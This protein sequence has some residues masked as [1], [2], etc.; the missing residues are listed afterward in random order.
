MKRFKPI[1]WLFLFGSIWGINEVFLGEILYRNDVQNSSVILTVMALFLLAISRGMINKPGSSALI[2]TFAVLFRLANTAPSYCH[3]LGIFLLGATFD[4]FSSLL[5]KNKDQAPLRWS[6]TGMVSAFGNNALFALLITNV[7]R[8]EYWVAGG[9][10]KVFHHIF[11]S[12]S[13]TTVI[14]ALV[15]PL[16][17]FVGKNG[18]IL[19]D[20]RPRWSYAGTILV[21]IALWT[22]A[23]F[24]G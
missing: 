8:Y 11:I 4:V 2:G 13:M 24:L 22:A 14:S 18:G 10:S 19:F 3:L 17:F 12:G 1:M 5:V 15:V 7:F 23:K 16:G 21:S 6:A 9:S 20:R